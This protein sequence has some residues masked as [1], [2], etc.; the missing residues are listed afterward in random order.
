MSEKL[1]E[2]L[3][4]KLLKKLHGNG[5]MWEDTYQSIDDDELVF[6]GV[7]SARWASTAKE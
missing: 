2:Q 4:G 3:L 6:H 5:G 1:S 7:S